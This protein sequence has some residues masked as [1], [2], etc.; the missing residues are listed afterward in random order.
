MAKANI[1]TAIRKAVKDVKAYAK[2][3]GLKINANA[4][5]GGSGIFSQF[6]AA[7]YSNKR[8]WV[9][10]PWPADFKRTMTV[11]DRQELTRKRFSKQ[12]NISVQRLRSRQHPTT[13]TSRYPTNGQCRNRTQGL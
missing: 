12:L 11:F 5:G 6:E 10:T 4:G 3:H 8:Q 13:F 1:K 9:N 7:K 2:K